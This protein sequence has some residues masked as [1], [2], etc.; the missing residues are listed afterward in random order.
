M[1]KKIFRMIEPKEGAAYR[2]GGLYPNLFCA[3]PPFQIDGNLGYTAGVA[4]VLVQS[5]GEELAILPALPPAWEKGT[6]KGLK[7]RGGITVDIRWDK[8][9]VGY[10][11][12]SDTDRQVMVSVCG[13]EKKKVS[14]SGG[15][16]YREVWHG[17][18]SKASNGD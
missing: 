10:L 8:E 5:H 2:G 15:T 16:D 13:G 9:Q 6:V 11:L 3:H 14:L 18:K 1:L 4:E 17:G 7:A 12:H